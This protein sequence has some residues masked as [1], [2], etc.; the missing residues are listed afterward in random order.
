MKIVIIGSGWYGCHIAKKYQNKHEIIIL[1]KNSEIFSGASYNNQNRLHLG[2]HYPRSYFTR[3]LCKNYYNKFMDDYKNIVDK[4]DKNYYIISK[5]SLLDYNTYL[6]IY[7]Y[8]N[9]NF[10][11]KENNIFNNIQGDCIDVNEQLI[12]HKKAKDY[13]INILSKVKI[14]TNYTVKSIN[15]ID[16][17]FIINNEIECDLILNCSFGQFIYNEPIPNDYYIYEKTVSF[18]YEKI[19]EF[20]INCITIMDGNFGSLYLRDEEKKLY[21]LTHVKYTP[22]IKSNNLET[23]LNYNPTI[24]K[25]NEHKEHMENEFKK[26]FINFDKYFKYKDYY[27]AFKIKKNTNYDDRSCNIYQDNNYI[28][29]NCGKITGI[30]DFEN[31]LSNILN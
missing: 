20:D 15:K 8:E 10:E 11:I 3:Q 4:I 22:L 13:F 27:L 7:K 12:N 31:Y 16:N 25:L 14:N 21:S 17:K 28:S 29:V 2:F 5:E 18:I 30:Y 6:N 23:I 26:Y 1:E 9:Y 19:N 24:E